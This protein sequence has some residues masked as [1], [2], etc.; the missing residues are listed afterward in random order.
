VKAGLPETAGT[1]HGAAALAALA[2][3][4][5]AA[6]LTGHIHEPYDIAC[7][8]AGRTVRLIGAGTLSRRV[9][10]SPASFNEL[11]IADGRIETICRTMAVALDTE[12]PVTVTA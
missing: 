8:V 11:R 12:L 9:R 4:G 10:H 1:R 3:A 2:S 5:V 7:P 6:V